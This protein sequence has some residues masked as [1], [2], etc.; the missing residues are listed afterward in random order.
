MDPSKEDRQTDVYVVDSEMS[1]VH[2]LLTL[3]S[4]RAEKQKFQLIHVHNAK[5][6]QLFVACPTQKK[7]YITKID[8]DPETESK[9]LGVLLRDYLIATVDNF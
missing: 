2:Q 1:S 5:S 6:D 3:D 4:E 7:L 9:A 8:F